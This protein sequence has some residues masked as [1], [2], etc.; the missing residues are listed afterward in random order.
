M[1]LA[2]VAVHAPQLPAPTSSQ[3][4]CAAVLRRG[5][6]VEGT[7]HVGDELGHH[8]WVGSKTAP[9]QQQL[10]DLQLTLG[11]ASRLGKRQ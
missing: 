2:L 7:G 10:G 8:L 5:A 1:A 4:Q 11:Q 3:A 9:R 6:V